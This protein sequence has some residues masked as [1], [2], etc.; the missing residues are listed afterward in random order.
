MTTPASTLPPDYDP[1]LSLADAQRMLT[2]AIAEA[3]RNHWPMVI[4]IV[5]SAAR[6]TLLA[7]MEHAQG[8]SIEVAQAKAR[9]A[10]NF[11][12]P[13]K[14]F[15]EAI[16]AGGKGLRT[17]AIPESARSKAA[18]RYCAMA[19]CWARSASPGCAPTRTRSLRLR[20]SR[21]SE[22]LRA[23]ARLMSDLECEA[24]EHALGDIA[25]QARRMRNIGFRFATACVDP[26]REAAHVVRRVE[27]HHHLVVE[28]ETATVQVG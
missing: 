16:A 13:T 9:T 7:R 27:R 20:A 21:R 24:Q 26:V 12:R 18:C 10:V 15:E 8:G 5:D 6:L 11:K 23:S 22:R 19:R 14:A 28:E 2:A 1:T 3:E 25:E 4:A 17:L